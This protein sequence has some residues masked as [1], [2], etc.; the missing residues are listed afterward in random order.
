MEDYLPQKNVQKAVG[1]MWRKYL[2]E[3]DKNLKAH[4]R[5]R[6]C[7]QD[8]IIRITRKIEYRVVIGGQA[9]LV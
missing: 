3:R 8:N 6:A 2:L 4:K 5:I 1:F 9:K 7:L